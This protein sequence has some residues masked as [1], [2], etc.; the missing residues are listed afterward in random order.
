MVTMAVDH[1]GTLLTSFFL[2]LELSIFE[3][4]HNF[5]S[6]IKHWHTEGCLGKYVRA[7]CGYNPLQQM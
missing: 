6:K 4:S 5:H 1:G 7:S 2:A 3:Q